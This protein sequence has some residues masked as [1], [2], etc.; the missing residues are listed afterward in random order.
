MSRY[1]WSDGKKRN[2]MKAKKTFIETE[3]DGMMNGGPNSASLM[4]VV[5]KKQKNKYGEYPGW[6][7]TPGEFPRTM[8]YLSGDLITTD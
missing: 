8:P 1:I 5:N 7:I 3:E 4:A 2:T 6:R